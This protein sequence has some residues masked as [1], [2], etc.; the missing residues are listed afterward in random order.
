MAVAGTAPRRGPALRQLPAPIDTRAY[1]SIELTVRAPSAPGCQHGAVGVVAVE[2]LDTEHVARQLDSAAAELAGAGNHISRLL[3]ELPGSVV[4]MAGDLLGP[5]RRGLFS[6]A[7][8]LAG[9]AR[10]VREVSQGIE[11]AARE[12]GA[13]MDLPGRPGVLVWDRPDII[14]PGPWRGP[15]P[16]AGQPPGG[17]SPGPDWRPRPQPDPSEHPRRPPLPGPLIPGIGAAGRR[18]PAPGRQGGVTSP[19]DAGVTGTG[20]TVRPPQQPIDPGQHLTALPGSDG[21]I[22]QFIALGVV[23]AQRLGQKVNGRASAG[24]GEGRRGRRSR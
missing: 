4:L 5:V 24:R 8:E 23:V 13:V 16:P 9:L 18:G 22:F 10:E 20:I 3:G 17:T 19:G 7:E 21:Q 11:Q 12:G 15:R 1:R 6:E 14:R 2:P